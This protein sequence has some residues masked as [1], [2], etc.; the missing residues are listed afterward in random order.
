LTEQAKIAYLQEKIH[1]AK[2]KERGGYASVI[3]GASFT[4]VGVICYVLYS[5]QLLGIG[6]IIL[7]IILGV[8]GYVEVFYYSAQ[9]T[10]SMEEL[11]LMATTIKCPKCGKQILQKTPYCPFC[12]NS[13]NSS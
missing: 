11:R 6:L 13:L 7:G 1:E 12:G 8:T 10:K 4:I 3:I 2:R 9:M 5:H